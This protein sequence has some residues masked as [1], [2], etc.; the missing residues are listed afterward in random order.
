MGVIDIEGLK[1]RWQAMLQ[2]KAESTAY[3]QQGIAELAVASQQ[4]GTPAWAPRVD[5]DFDGQDLETGMF[6]VMRDG[7]S[8]DEFWLECQFGAIIAPSGN[9]Y[10]HNKPSTPAA[11][12]EWVA[13][14]CGYS[15][16]RVKE[17]FEE[18]LLGQPRG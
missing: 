13:A 8:H 17:A 11:L 18:A 4:I 12:G 16:D 10:L 2:A 15:T 5:R 6:L 3:A 1:A 9:T 14:R 7:G